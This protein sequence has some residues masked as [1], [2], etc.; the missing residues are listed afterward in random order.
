MLLVSMFPNEIYDA[1]VNDIRKIELRIDKYFPKAI[2]KFKRTRTFPT[3][4]VDD[5]VIPATKN[6]HV[7]FYYAGNPSEILRPHYTTFSI[8]T[9]DNQRYVVRGIEMLY[10]PSPGSESVMLPQV[11]SYTSHFL[12]RYN[13][14]FLQQKNITANEIAGLFIIKNPRPFII[15]I[16]EDIKSNF[17]EYGEF[18]THGIKVDGGFCF[19]RTALHCDNESM[20]KKE[21]MLIIYTT[22]VSNNEMSNSQKEAIDRVCIDTIKSCVDNINDYCSIDIKM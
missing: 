17:E 16:N 11:H 21:T 5:Y 4:Y 13:E 3:W 12:Q 8:I 14:R 2:N 1:I 10:K 22:F 6:E 18:N 19:A 20:E 9:S 15:E 7:T